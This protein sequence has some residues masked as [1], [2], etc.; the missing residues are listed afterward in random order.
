MLAVP[1]TNQRDEVLGAMQMINALDDQDKK[2]KVI[3]FLYPK[4]ITSAHLQIDI[5]H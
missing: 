1:I 4:K 3:P 5:G 2:D